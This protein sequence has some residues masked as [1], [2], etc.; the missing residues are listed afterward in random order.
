MVDVWYV[1]SNVTSDGNVGCRTET[2]GK[3]LI[4]SGFVGVALKYA[5]PLIAPFLHDVVAEIRAEFREWR[6]KRRQ[7]KQR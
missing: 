7:Q 5:W 2:M 4:I 6:A 1:R 3:F